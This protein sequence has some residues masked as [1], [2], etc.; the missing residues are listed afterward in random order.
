MKISEIGIR[1]DTIFTK[2]TIKYNNNIIIKKAN[3]YAQTKCRIVLY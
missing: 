1:N 2:I 3:N